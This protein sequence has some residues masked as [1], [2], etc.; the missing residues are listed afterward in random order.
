MAIEL[1]DRRQHS[2]QLQQLFHLG[3]DQVSHLA[4]FVRRHVAG[5]KN[6]PVHSLLGEYEWAFIAATHRDGRRELLAVEVVQS[7]GSVRGKVVAN[8]LPDDGL[9][10]DAVG[11]EEMARPERPRTPARRDRR[12]HLP[13]WN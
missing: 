8:L 6:P 7:L 4:K 10:A 3:L 2:N 5:I 1:F 11:R 13:G 9:Q 12:N